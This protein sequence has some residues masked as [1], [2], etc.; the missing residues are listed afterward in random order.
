MKP[1]DPPDHAPRH[2]GSAR[3]AGKL[4]LITGGASGIGRAVAELFAREKARVVV[5]SRAEDAEAP[6]FVAGLRAEGAE[7]TLLTMDVR[8]RRAVHHAIGRAVERQ[9][10]LDILVCNAGIQKVC[11]D[12]TELTEEDVA[13]VFDTNVMGCLWV[14]QAALPHLREGGAIVLTTSATA[15]VGN[16]ELVDYSA[17]KGAGVALVRSLALQLAPR[18]IRVNGVAPG[19]VWTPMIAASLPAGEIERFGT[20]VPLG[21]PA[22]PNEIAPSFLFLASSDASYMTGQILHPNGGMPVAS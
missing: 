2:P 17:T 21:R 19:P 15:Y 6:G 1:D 20:D 22:Q 5:A 18:G 16:A 11:H 14:V 7:A 12:I 4:A 8:D 9:G 10:P 13:A 3:L